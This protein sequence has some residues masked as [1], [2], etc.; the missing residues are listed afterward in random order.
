MQVR[1]S[2]PLH[3]AKAVPSSCPIHSFQT[4]TYQGH[5]NRTLRIQY[6]V[7]FQQYFIPLTCRLI[8]RFLQIQLSTACWRNYFSPHHRYKIFNTLAINLLENTWHFTTVP[9][10]ETSCMESPLRTCLPIET[11]TDNRTPTGSYR[12]VSHGSPIVSMVAR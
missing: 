10:I 7:L 4:L 1:G 12:P 2:L 5:K 8:L 3:V 9:M 11:T 6:L